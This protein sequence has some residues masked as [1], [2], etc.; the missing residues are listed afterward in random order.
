MSKE[1]TLKIAKQFLKD[2]HQIELRKFTSIADDAAA[3]LAK[4]KV[5]LHLSGLTTITDAAAASLAK[6]KG[7][8]LFLESLTELSDAAAQAL[9]KYKGKNL[10]LDGLTSLSDAAAQALAKLERE[11]LGLNGLTELSDAAAAS[12]AKHKGDLCLDVLT[13]RSDSPG[14]KAL[15]K[16]LGHH[17]GEN[18]EILKEAVMQALAGQALTKHEILDGIKA[19]GYK[20]STKDPMNSLNVLL[21]TGKTFQKVEGGK[22]SAIK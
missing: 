8:C 2:S 18:V 9:A 5:A 12:L 19:I 1:L 6:S 17:R 13:S 16:R 21:Y 7:E 15:A 10:F 4:C 22:F 11:Y 3:A 20:F 14:H